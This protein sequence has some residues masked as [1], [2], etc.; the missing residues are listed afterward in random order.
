MRF[1]F[2]FLLLLTSCSWQP[3]SAE[4]REFYSHLK[5]PHVRCG[6]RIKES[7]YFLVLL[8]DAC[9][10]DYSDNHTFLRTMV[11]HPSDGSKNGDVGH[12]WIYLEGWKEGK[13]V[14]LEGGQSGELGI[15]QP[16]YF[17]GVMD[18]IDAGHPNP[19][20]YLWDTLHDGFFDWGGGMHTPTYAVK[21]NLTEKQ[22]LD[23]FAWVEC[24][25]FSTYSITNCQCT[26]FVCGAARFAG[27]ELEDKVTIPIQKEV[28][29]RSCTLPLRTNDQYA[30]LTISTPDVL[31]K[32]LMKLVLEGQGEYAVQWYRS[33]RPR[34]KR[35]CLNAWQNLPERV[36]RFY[37]CL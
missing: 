7:D 17:D 22:F 26:T 32:S 19:I 20:S 27:L 36:R 37:L 6:N 30:F 14:Y 18:R 9:H 5:Q 33:R 3:R 10:L 16:R 24:Y 21:V 2:L 4:Y 1:L 28:H 31:E 25:D 23:L 35:D 34:A 29:L 12:S 11:K 8:V 15:V 13:R